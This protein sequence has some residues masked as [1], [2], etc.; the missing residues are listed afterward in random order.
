MK[1]KFKGKYLTEKKCINSI[2]RFYNLA[3]TSELKEGLNWYNDAKQYCIELADRFNVKVSQVA[4]IIAAFS[5]QTGWTENKRW[6]L[7]F[8]ISPNN[9][10]KND[11]QYEKAKAIL[12]LTN[13]ADIYQALSLNG[14]AWKT[15]A[16]FLN[17]LNPDVTTEVTIDRHAIAAC[18]QSPDK[19]EALSDD[20]GK[21]TVKQYR[22]LEQ[23]Y[24]NAAIELG[25]LPQQLQAIVWTVYRRLRDLKQH[26]SAKGWQPFDTDV[27]F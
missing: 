16:F 12:K 8:L 21:L 6:T 17:M 1:Q 24:G 2:T 18:I 26:E 4:G 3:T 5:P 15:K 13:E 19:V 20:Y 22:F 7:S 10:I 11:V 25:I 27:T 14:T 9:W 23:C